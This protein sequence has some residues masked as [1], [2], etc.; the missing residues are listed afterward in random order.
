MSTIQ[1]GSFCN[2]GLV[3]KSFN[4][5]CFPMAQNLALFPLCGVE[6][7]SNLYFQSRQ[8]SLPFPPKMSILNTSL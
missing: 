6:T 2:Y 5:S 8:R 1:A 3:Y 7:T 4:V